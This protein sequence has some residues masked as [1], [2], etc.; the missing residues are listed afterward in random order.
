MKL[1]KEIKEKIDAYFD[2]ILATELFEI[3]T[4]KYGFTES[5]IEL[6]NQSFNTIKKSYYSTDNASFT[7]IEEKKDTIFSFVA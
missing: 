4:K 1:S 6:E 3:A 5:N 7:I 2:S